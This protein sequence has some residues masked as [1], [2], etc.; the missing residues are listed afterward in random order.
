MN[1]VQTPNTV[2]DVVKK[3]AGRSVL[4]YQKYTPDTLKKCDHEFWILGL[5]LYHAFDGVHNESRLQTKF[6][7]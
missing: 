7:L 6:K 3:N 2:M 1:E 4:L 5:R